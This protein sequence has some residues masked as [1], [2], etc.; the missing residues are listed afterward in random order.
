MG[1]SEN[2]DVLEAR[3]ESLSELEAGHA[4]RWHT[5]KN[6]RV[7]RRKAYELREA[8]YIASLFPEKY[9]AL[10]EAHRTFSIHVIEPGLIEAKLK[11]TH[12]DD[13]KVMP[14]AEP[15]I[16]GIGPWGRPTST[17]GKTTAEQVIE[18]WQAHMPSLDPVHFQQTFLP[19][20]EL[21]KLYE[22]S[23]TQTPRMMILTAEGE[24]WLTLSLRDASMDDFAWKPSQPAPPLVEEKL[25][26]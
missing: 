10:A 8:L 15:P 26:L 25:D 24:G 14:G 20:D 21:V 4:C 12:T 7:T 16:H 23:R 17:V 5:T 3:R 19:H 22:W 2:P 1:Y 13:L 9:P 11:P 6:K 18:S